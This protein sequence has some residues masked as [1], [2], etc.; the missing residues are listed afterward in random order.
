MESKMATSPAIDE[1][2]QRPSAFVEKAMSSSQ[3]D[4]LKLDSA[5]KKGSAS[6]ANK[7]VKKPAQQLQPA[8]SSSAR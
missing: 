3:Q 4:K 1:Q 5:V 6:A 7:A 8:E 2:Q